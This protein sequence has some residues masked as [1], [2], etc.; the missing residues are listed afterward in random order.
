MIGGTIYLEVLDGKPVEL[1]GEEVFW[2]APR[3]EKSEPIAEKISNWILERYSPAQLTEHPDPFPIRVRIDRIVVHKYKP[4]RFKVTLP[5]IET[6][7][8]IWPTQTFEFDRR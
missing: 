6:N 4:K 8:N 5:G 3:N 2:I 7:G 1:R